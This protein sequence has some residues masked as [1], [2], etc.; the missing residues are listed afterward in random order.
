MFLLEDFFAHPTVV[1]WQRASSQMSLLARTVALAVQTVAVLSQYESS[2]LLILTQFS[3]NLVAPPFNLTNMQ[4]GKHCEQKLRMCP[5]DIPD[6]NHPLISAS[7]DS[8]NCIKN[9]ILM[10]SEMCTRLKTYVGRKR[11]TKKIHE[12]FFFIFFYFSCV[13]RLKP[14]K[15]L[16]WGWNTET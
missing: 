10:H 7:T 1:S 12:R 11:K 2:L 16:V 15:I 4:S 13:P 5:E 6:N 14:Q 3:L 9:W 8:L